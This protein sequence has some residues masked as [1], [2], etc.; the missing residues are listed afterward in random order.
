MI[1][2]VIFDMDGVLLDSEPFWQESEMKVFASVGI[3]LTRSQCIETTGLRVIEVVAY[4]F[5]Q[6]PWNHFSVEQVSDKILTNV[7]RL[8]REHAVPLN[9]VMELLEF[10]KSRSIPI[11]VASSSPTKLI[12]AVLQKL[13]LERL[14]SVIHSAEN[15]E[16]GKPHPAVFLSTAKKMHSSPDHCLVF[17]DSFNGLIAA[18]AARMKTVVVP[19]SAQWKEPRFNIADLKLKSLVRFSEYHWK[20]LNAIQ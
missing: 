12:N 4:R 18:K 1:K 2:S 16:F 7:I 11:A 15:E 6:Q 20:R 8:V 19:M 3:H 17:E 14:F 9:G 5:N 10:F 13:R